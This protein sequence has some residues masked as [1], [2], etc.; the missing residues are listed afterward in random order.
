MPDISAIPSLFNFLKNKDWTKLLIKSPDGESF[1][2]KVEGKIYKFYSNID[3]VN[4]DVEG[5]HKKY[6]LSIPKP[7]KG[8][9]GTIEKQQEEGIVGLYH[10]PEVSTKLPPDFSFFHTAYVEYDY[11]VYCYVLGIDNPI[12]GSP[13]LGFYQR[14]RHESSSL[15]ELIVSGRT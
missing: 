15:E 10:D 5:R 1:Y 6:F 12:F 4:L 13:S 2:I 14:K 9:S 3:E 11:G 7:Y 8:L